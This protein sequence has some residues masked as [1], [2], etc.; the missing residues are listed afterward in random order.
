MNYYFI[1]CDDF[2][3]S[4]IDWNTLHTGS[5]SQECSELVLDRFL[6]QHIREPTR[7]E[8]VRDL[9]FSSNE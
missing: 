7:G 6:I 2:S 8:N 1:I 9:V 4:S 5:E 3:H